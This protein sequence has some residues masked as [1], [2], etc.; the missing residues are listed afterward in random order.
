MGRPVGRA[1][2][3]AALLGVAAPAW[4]TPP[5]VKVEYSPRQDLLC[6]VLP[7]SSIK[8]EWKAELLSRQADFLQLWERE[9]PGL[10]AAAEKISGRRFPS[11]D[12]VA[13]L[14][15]CNSPSESFPHANQV[16]LNMRHALASFSP[17]P[18]TLRYKA[19]TLF[20]ELLHIHLF[21]RPMESSPLLQA[22]AA[23][24]QRVRGHL[25]LLAL[26][27]RFSWSSARAMRWRR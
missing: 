24:H 17:R 20:H 6:S 18:V 4:A 12:V 23:E 11:P 15:L 13:R 14:T 22:H 27:R 7:G 8:E 21:R 26:K 3:V 2:L 5:R 1:L 9:G 19:H 16:T 25:H 10:I